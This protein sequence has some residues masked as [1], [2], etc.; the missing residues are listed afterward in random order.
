MCH[1]HCRWLAVAI[2]LTAMHDT[3]SVANLFTLQRLPEY[4]HS[5]LLIRLLLSNC[6]RGVGYNVGVCGVIHLREIPVFASM[7]VYC[8]VPVWVSVVKMKEHN[9]RVAVV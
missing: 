1:W 6:K 5:L 9:W 8:V 3:V 7:H 2:H 4:D